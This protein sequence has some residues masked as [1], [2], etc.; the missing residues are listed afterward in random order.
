MSEKGGVLYVVATPI[1]NLGD[2]SQRAIETLRTVDLIAAEDTRHSRPLLQHYGIRTPL[3]SCHEHNEAQVS[4]RLVEQLQAGQ[5]IAL[6]SDAG[7]PL[8]SDPGYQLVRAAIEAGV[9]VLA[10]PGPSALVAALSVSGL[11][12]DRFRFEGFLPAKS[13]ARRE[14]LQALAAETAT[15]V[16]YE[17]SHR[18]RTGLADM[19]AAFGD[20]RYA[21]LA[22]ELTK[23]F[24]Q[25]ERGA[26][27]HLRQW[28]EADANRRKGEFVVMVQGAE[29]PTGQDAA[30][31]RRILEI[32]LKRL[33]VKQAA[34]IAAE[35]TGERRNA[36]YQLALGLGTE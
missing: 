31:T 27:S 33:P 23:R 10:V 6:I 34:A 28:V 17:S 20:A 4:P 21:V 36:L 5:R 15:L 13:G 3:Q 14:R 32:L 25:T 1:G 26:L 29:A 30:E 12:T 19:A 16:F 8:V 22:R 11:P 18:I 7:T 35:I 9:V 24:E 2:L